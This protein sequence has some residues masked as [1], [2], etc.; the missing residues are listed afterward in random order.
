MYEKG[1]KQGSIKREKVSKETV[2]NKIHRLKFPKKTSY[3]DKKK[4][5]EYLYIDAD[6]DHISLQFREKKEIL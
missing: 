1:G 2:K 4:V 6:E 5:V 3:P